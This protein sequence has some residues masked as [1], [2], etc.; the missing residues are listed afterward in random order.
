MCQKY[1]RKGT[2]FLLTLGIHP[3]C[4]HRYFREYSWLLYKSIL[5][6]WPLILILRL[7]K[8][9]RERNTTKKETM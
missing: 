9:I 1:L 3:K 4:S 6:K 7:A 5:K 2:F 8:I